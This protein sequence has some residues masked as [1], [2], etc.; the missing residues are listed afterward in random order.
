MP[1]NRSTIRVVSSTPRSSTPTRLL[2]D[3][4]I[5]P[6]VRLLSP[7]TLIRQR[8]GYL[9]VERRAGALTGQQQIRRHHLVNLSGFQGRPR[10]EKGQP[11]MSCHPIHR[12]Q[13]L[14]HE[15]DVRHLLMASA[16]DLKPKHCDKSLRL[17]NREPLKSGRPLAMQDLVLKADIRFWQDVFE[18]LLGGWP[19]YRCVYEQLAVD[20]PTKRCGIPQ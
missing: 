12:H 1:A 13:V 19:P 10:A 6:D 15:V 3:G 11:L 14:H 2:R 5:L 16:S 8:Q 18:G 20:R 4:K 7:A 9:T 17:F